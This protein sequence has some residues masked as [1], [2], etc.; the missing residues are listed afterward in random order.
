MEG[1]ATVERDITDRKRSE[2]ELKEL[3][4]ALERRAEQ[5]RFLAS[6]LTMAEQN[7]QHRLAQILHDGLQQILVGAKFQI[8][9]LEHS[10]DAAQVAADVSSLI[11]EAIKTSRQLTSE[12]GPP[13]LHQGGLIPGLEWLVGWMRDRHGLNVDLIVPEKIEKLPESIFVF[14]F[15]ATRELL[16]NVVKHAGVTSACIEVTKTEG[17]IQLI[18]ED[19]GKGFD[20]S[21]FTAGDSIK[22][23]GL[24][25]LRERLNMMGGC[26]QIESSPGQGSRFKIVTPYSLP[27]EKALHAVHRKPD[28]SSIVSGLPLVDGDSFKKIRV[29]LADDHT[30]VR[31]GLSSLLKLERDIDV[32]GEAP[33][34]E[35]AVEMVRKMRPDVVLMDINMPGM[36]GIE[37]SRIIH[38]ELPSVRVIGLSMF[39]EGEQAAAMRDAGAVDYIDK[40]GPSDVLLR[41]IRACMGKLSVAE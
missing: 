41:G 24:F 15:Q 12:L 34:G 13:I 10:K 36:N 17:F 31:Q 38:R 39:R 33:D 14:L 1:L 28:A 6:E 11:D 19:K 35:S 21:R 5:L 40:S 20:P 7:E 27:A 8:A 32:V 22:G 18:V 23:I 2:K 16:F 25:S 26:L 37:A 4:G 3:N 9:L 29:L 30:V